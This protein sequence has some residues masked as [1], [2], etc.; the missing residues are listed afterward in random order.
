MTFDATA[1]HKAI[2]KTKRGGS[3]ATG[4]TN[5][6]R[7]NKYEP[8]DG[9]LPWEQQPKE[10]TALFHV[11][12]VYRDLGPDRTMRMLA[13][14]LE[15]LG[16]KRRI[17]SL[18]VRSAELCWVSR[19]R[20]W[21]IE[22]DR[23]V[24][25]AATE[26][27]KTHA[28]NTVI[29]TGNMM[30]VAHKGLQVYEQLLNEWAADHKKA[31]DAGE[32]TPAPPVTVDEIAKLADCANKISQLVQGKPTEITDSTTDVTVR[33][34]LSA[35]FVNFTRSKILGIGDPTP[36]SNLIVDA[37]EPLNGNG[38]GNGSTPE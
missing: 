24:R 18:R 25:I 11:F 6:V 27:A 15:T 29:T 23:L 1:L 10:G 21:D 4:G 33:K 2:Q 5:D 14:A 12:T 34:G 20:L 19:A 38:N 17:P 16:I 30:V 28:R 9:L 32:P 26:Q 3:G 7:M 36:P 37:V 13:G 22:Q 35:E 31:K 8:V